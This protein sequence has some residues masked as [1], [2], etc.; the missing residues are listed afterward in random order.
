MTAFPTPAEARARLDLAARTNDTG[1]RASH[2][3][4]VGRA[5]RK[6]FTAS[7]QAEAPKAF[8]G[9]EAWEPDRYET[10]LLRDVAENDSPAE[11]SAAAKRLGKVY[12]E[13]YRR[14][15][16][17]SEASTTYGG[18]SG[19]VAF[20][21]K[22]SLAE[23]NPRLVEMVETIYGKVGSPPEAPSEDCSKCGYRVGV[24][25]PT[26]SL[27]TSEAGLDP[28]FVQHLRKTGQPE[29]VSLESWTE[30]QGSG[31][32]DPLVQVEYGTALASAWEDFEKHLLEKRYCRPTDIPASNVYRGYRLL[33]LDT[34]LCP[35]DFR[36]Q[37]E[38][39]TSGI[40]YE[41]PLGPGT[42]PEI[43]YE[44]LVRRY[45]RQLRQDTAPA[46][47]P[48]LPEEIAEAV[49]AIGFPPD[50]TALFVQATGLALHLHN[51]R[52]WED[53]RARLTPG[54]PATPA[55]AS[56]TRPQLSVARQELS[57]PPPLVSSTRP[58]GSVTSP[59]A[60]LLGPE[61]QEIQAAVERLWQSLLPEP[62]TAAR[63]TVEPGIPGGAWPVTQFRQHIGS[64]ALIGTPQGQGGDPERYYPG[65]F[66]P[67]VFEEKVRA[68]AS[69]YGEVWSAAR[70]VLGAPG[71][72]ER[73]VA[74][75]KIELGPQELEAHLF[76]IAR[77]A[78]A[79]HG[80]R[81]GNVFRP[82]GHGPWQTE[83]VIL[84]DNVTVPVT[85]DEV[86]KELEQGS[87]TPQASYE[88]LMGAHVERLVRSYENALDVVLTLT[89]APT[90]PPAA[91]STSML[92]G[93]APLTRADIPDLFHRWAQL[94]WQVVERL[95]AVRL[96]VGD[97]F[98][99]LRL[100]KRTG[101]F[102]EVPRR[103]QRGEIEPEPKDILWPGHPRAQTEGW[104]LEPIPKPLYRRPFPGIFIQ[105]LHAV[106][107]RSRGF[108]IGSNLYSVSLL[109]EEEQKIVVKSFKDTT[110][111]VTESTAE[112]IFEESSSETERDFGDEMMRESE[113]ESTSEEAGHIGTK[114]SGGVPFFSGSV[115]AS[116]DAK[117]GSR[118]FAKDVSKVTSKL[119]SKLSAK[120]GVSVETKRSTEQ[121][122][123]L[124]SELNT[125]RTI[126][127][128]NLGHTVTFHWFQMT[129]KYLQQLQIEDAR[130]VYTSGK[131][132]VARVFV[133]PGAS[134][135][136]RLKEVER[137]MPENLQVE[138]VAELPADVAALLPA[139]VAIVITS[140][141]Y[142]EVV[143]MAG[144][145][146]FLAKVLT[147][148]KAAEVSSTV[149][150]LLGDS[151]AAPDGLGVLAFSDPQRQ[152]S[153]HDSFVEL[154]SEHPAQ[155]QPA[156]VPNLVAADRIEIT[157]K[158]ERGNPQVVHLP[159]LDLR[160]KVRD[161]Q[162]P[163][164]YPA[165]PYDSQSL[166]RLLGAEERIVNTN[167]VYCDAMV[168]RCT[169]LE[170][171]LQR[172]RDLD[173]LEKK[174]QVGQQEIELRWAAEKEG[175]DVVLQEKDESL[176][177][178]VAAREGQQP[179][180]DRL[181]VER[182]QFAER[183]KIAED[184]LERQRLETE[185]D[186]LRRK[187]DQLQ[188]RVGQPPEVKIDAPQGANV[189]VEA[190][191]NIDADGQ[192]DGASITVE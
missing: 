186:I 138:L 42:P 142:R 137:D 21:G 54:A 11:R 111:T 171:Y 87:A 74:E 104:M 96:P 149:W 143:S 49:V 99:V 72:R 46:S 5:Y 131:Y 101:R 139:D 77:Y 1:A 4:A 17:A 103:S 102:G 6:I 173:L 114:L 146:A 188:A 19:T 10:A 32:E 2:V 168:G 71:M 56:G 121:K 51:L 120:R 130:L 158:W 16:V 107:L 30:Q 116:Y 25:K 179:F 175:L 154:F 31:P 187:V 68:L 41:G 125:E 147:A 34:Q 35:Q 109:P 84:S 148:E 28:A 66:D 13:A 27:T 64:L 91:T 150:R 106:S 53:I 177:A 63:S 38:K 93:T 105:E 98:F 47:R 183:K 134:V 180:Q 97:D 80:I 67:K 135:P 119:A 85:Y 48:V 133:P 108:G 151:D 159:N 86:V 169:A 57:F 113:R 126:K 110:Y 176:V 167:G 89:G 165:N 145:N 166:P 118:D 58:A 50:R 59:A 185:L 83:T 161:G 123:E 174:A 20:V 33:R 112:N 157:S 60:W 22:A 3:E 79:H 164:R 82:P 62:P 160:Y 170:D 44:E 18:R 155:S 90:A 162:P 115:D 94:I 127:N 26:G 136:E 78:T 29:L 36:L 76:H 156:W 95:L 70:A 65:V 153:S 88:V 52:F 178:V 192:D 152:A 182:A 129:R 92:P 190:K 184:Q 191:V 45:I 140:D 8:G 40:I 69:I 172:H 141:P 117:S 55:A 43:D 163:P 75:P 132:N 189:A 7:R 100:S 37:C 9:G 128:P 39:Q 81:D 73:M 124:H 24:R 14:V 122:V 144:A 12:S 61:G 181:E 23:P 15:A